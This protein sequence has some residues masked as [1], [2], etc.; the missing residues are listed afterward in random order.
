MQVIDAK[1]EAV[2][3]EIPIRIPGLER[4][5]GVLPIGLAYHEKSEIGRAHV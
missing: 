3:A 1:T 5:R 2:E 4:Y